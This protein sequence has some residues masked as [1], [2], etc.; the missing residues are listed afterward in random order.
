MCG[1][2]ARSWKSQYCT[3][4]LSSSV[5][6]TFGL[7]YDDKYNLVL[8]CQDGKSG[9]TREATVKKSVAYFV[10]VNGAVVGDMVD[11]EVTKLH[12]SLVSER[13]DK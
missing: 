10:D 4:P 3:S 5:H 8:S 13:K 6:Y 11:V 1:Q 7:R 9:S 2:Q 12:N